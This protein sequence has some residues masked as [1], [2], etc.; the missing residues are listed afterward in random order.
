MAV[1]GD[2]PLIWHVMG[3]YSASG[4]D[5][6]VLCLG[7]KGAQIRSYFEAQAEV[8]PD[9]SGTL[10][11]HPAPGITWRVDM[12]DTGDDAQT[13]AR[14]LAVRERL[15]ETRFLA[16]YGDGVANININELLAFH[17]RH[18]RLGT[19]TVVRPFSQF[20]LVGLSDSDMVSEFLEKP[21]ITEWANGGFFVFEPGIFD[22][23][24]QGPLESHPFVRLTSDKQLMAYRL[25]AFWACLDTYKDLI[26]LDDLW[27]GGLPPWSTLNRW[28]SGTTQA[29]TGTSA[30]SF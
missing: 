1:I 29:R 30:A 26:T 23:L 9:P 22:Y 19:I 7:H 13:G 17:E 21:R 2:R 8:G 14:I 10:V 5:D 6:F 11:I 25:D 28:N 3:V 4:F 12:V 18:G 27:Q 20:G 24:D 15:G 16:S